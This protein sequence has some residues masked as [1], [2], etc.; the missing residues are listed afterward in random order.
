LISG[1]VWRKFIRDQ[2]II[3]E[4]LLIIAISNDF[5]RPAWNWPEH[6]L[7]CIDNNVCPT[8][9]DYLWQPL[10]LD[11]P[12]DQLTK[13]TA[14]RFFGRYGEVNWK[15]TLL[16]LYLDDQSFL[17]AF[18]SRAQ[19]NLQAMMKGARADES[20][21]AIAQILP[22]TKAALESFKTLGIPV[23]VLMVPQRNEVGLLGDSVDRDAAVATLN[24][25]GIGHHWCPLLGSDFMPNDGHPTR[26][27]YDKLAA[28]ADRVLNDLK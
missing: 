3:V 1:G 18:G 25:H 16:R 17:L 26:A 27:G 23:Q 6:L 15:G 28:C 22:E 11:E 8:E 9:R 13:R 19:Q 21:R 7:A 14:T 12:Q 2:G 4:R 10:E 20:M 24:S 5:K